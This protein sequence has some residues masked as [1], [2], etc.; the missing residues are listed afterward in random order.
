MSLFSEHTSVRHM[1][2]VFF[3]FF[4]S[5]VWIQ[6]DVHQTHCLIWWSW[7]LKMT[8]RLMLGF[9]RQIHFAFSHFVFLFFIIIM[10]LRLLDDHVIYSLHSLFSA[11]FPCLLFLSIWR[12]KMRWF[13][14]REKNEMWCDEEEKIH[15]LVSLSV[16]GISLLW[17]SILFF[18][19]DVSFCLSDIYYITYICLVLG[20]RRKEKTIIRSSWGVKKVKNE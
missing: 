9:I 4:P 12:S 10:S 5:L 7:V 18:F 1:H 2:I 6:S 19:V 17:V 11:Y 16:R 20:A 8:M 14:R 3:F 13:S 15:Q